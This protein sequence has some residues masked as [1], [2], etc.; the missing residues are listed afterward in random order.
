MT[1]APDPAIESQEPDPALRCPACRA[2]DTLT[3]TADA[4][5]CPAC[6]AR[7]LRDVARGTAQLLAKG[8]H[9]TNKL[10]IQAWW[11]D[12]YKQL[13]DG[14][15]TTLDR[16]TLAG[17]L[18]ELEDMFCARQHLATVEMPLAELAGRTVLEIGPGCGAFGRE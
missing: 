14:H 9:T 15:E 7:Y 18:A 11:G 3:S 4:L 8:S 2:T 1:S 6:G 10:N 12:L 17:M 5:V 13:Y 16:E